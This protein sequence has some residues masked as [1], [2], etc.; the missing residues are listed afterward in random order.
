MAG[1][2]KGTA[3]PAPRGFPPGSII[4]P[5]PREPGTAAEFHISSQQSS[6]LLRTRLDYSFPMVVATP[7]ETK[8]PSAL[9]TDEKHERVSRL[10]RSILSNWVTYLA[11]GMVGFFLSPYVVRHLGNSGYGVWVLLVSL[12]GYMGFLDL[13]IRGSVTRYVAKFHSLKDHESSSRVVSS[14]CGI[15]LTLGMIGVV[16][17]FVFSLSAVPH[18]QIPP[19]FVRP[20]QIVVVIT[21]FTV[22]CSLVSGVFGGILV[23]LQRFELINSIEL[24]VLAARSAAILLALRSGK[25]LI[26]LALIQLAATLAELSFGFLLSLRLYPD[27]RPSVSKAD[28]GHVRLVFSFG[29]F[30]L[31]LQ[32]SNYLI[33]YTDALVIGAFLPIS[34]VTFFAIGGNL[35]IYARD[36]VSGVTRTMTPLASRL[37]VEAS[38]SR[39]QETTLKAGKYCSLAMLPIF[40]TFLL[41]GHTFIGLWMGAAY[42][43]LSGRVLTILSLPWLIGSGGSIVGAVMLGISKHKNVVPVAAAEGLSNLGLSVGLVRFYGIVGV[44]WGTAIPNLAVSLF[45]W[46]WYTH[47]TLG[48]SLARYASALWIR[49]LLAAI[50][51]AV[52]TALLERFTRPASLMGFFFQVCLALP[53]MAVGVWLIGLTAAERRSYQGRLFRVA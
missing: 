11:S 45:F 28:W 48:I 4:C 39:L 52:C 43:D 16:F 44:A 15:F 5:L 32:L 20:A 6:S 22:A 31:L 33:F 25:G 14:A 18:F 13:G 37:E 7:S 49:P 1:W 27:A 17:G 51:F 9:V 53:A 50:P 8:P 46:P 29:L 10:A 35:T 26:T 41:R 34:M 30:A 21:G 38:K 42:V 19:E 23:G 36:L 2:V 24:G 40:V 3:T 12:T 47:R